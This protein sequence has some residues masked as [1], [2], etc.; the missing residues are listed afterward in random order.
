MRRL[1]LGGALLLLVIGTANAAPILDEDGVVCVGADPNQ[2][3]KISV[4]CLNSC[5]IGVADVE[6]NASCRNERE[7]ELD[8]LVAEHD[9]MGADPVCTWTVRDSEDDEEVTVTIDSSDGLPVELQSFS[10]E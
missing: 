9:N 2:V 4:V 3:C 5:I 7:N 1:L 8:F 6:Q 10:V